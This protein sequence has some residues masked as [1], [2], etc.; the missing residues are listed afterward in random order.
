MNRFLIN[1]G[2]QIQREGESIRYKITTTPWANNPTNIIVE[3][4]DI[5]NPNNE[6]DVTLTTITGTSSVLGD[7]ITL[8]NLHSLDK[9]HK[10]R[11]DIYFNSSGNTLVIPLLVK[12]IR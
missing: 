5:T 9:N 12:G 4:W 11:V 2:V 7:V 8:P 6:L 10:Y 3:V 1:E